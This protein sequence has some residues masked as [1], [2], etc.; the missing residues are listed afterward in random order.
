MEEINYIKKYEEIEEKFNKYIKENYD[1]K[2]DKIKYKFEHT[3]RV[4]EYSE[5][6]ARE[7]NLDEENVFIAKVIALFHDLGRFEQIVKYN[8]FEDYKTMDHGKY[9]ADILFKDDLM[10]KFLED[11][12]YDSIF[13]EAILNHNKYEIETKRLTEQQLLHTKIIRDADK[14]DAFNIR[15][16]KDVLKTSKFS[17]EEL[18]NSL[19]SD[20]VYE[21]FMDEKTVLNTDVKTPV[22]QWM[23]IIAFVFGYNFVSGLKIIV[24]EE[25]M[26]KIKNKVEFKN[27]DTINK[28]QNMYTLVENYINYRIINDINF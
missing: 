9:A 12:Q 13:K 18:E 10:R 6:I 2:I 28:I 14:T 23:S 26:N 16:N 25:F 20:K 8:S 24:K 15:A 22:D 1:F 5:Y 3:H 11:S 27:E 7:L 17:K 4:V 21:E 19:L